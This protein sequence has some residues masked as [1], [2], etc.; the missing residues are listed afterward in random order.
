MSPWIQIT[1]PVLQTPQNCTLQDLKPF[2]RFTFGKSQTTGSV[3]N[4]CDELCKAHQKCCQ[5]FP[6]TLNFAT[7]GLPP[8]ALTGCGSQVE[9]RE[10]A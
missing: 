2:A 10:R 7:T 4:I 8:F 9:V 5:H 6:N 1:L 3:G